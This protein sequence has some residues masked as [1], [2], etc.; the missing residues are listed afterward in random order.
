M[1]PRFRSAVATLLADV[2]RYAMRYA[3]RDMVTVM[4]AVFSMM[5]AASHMAAMP[6][7]RC[8]YAATFRCCHADY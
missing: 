6:C 3:L 4:P 7:R 1:T 5:D 8:H 2:E